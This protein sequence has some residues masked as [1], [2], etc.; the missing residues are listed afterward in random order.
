MIFFFFCRSP[1][2]FFLARAPFVASLLFADFIILGSL[3]HHIYTSV[4]CRV[5]VAPYGLNANVNTRTTVSVALWIRLVAYWR[6]AHRHL[7]FS[8]RG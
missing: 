1:F 4:V 2:L 3:L 7:I 8:I 6:Q 5:A